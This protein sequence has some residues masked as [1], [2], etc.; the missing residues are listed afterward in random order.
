MSRHLLTRA[1]LGHWTL[2]CTIVLFTEP[3][4]SMSDHSMITDLTGVMRMF[5]PEILGLVF[6]GVMLVVV[7]E[8]K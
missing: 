7:L 2:A 3:E 6:M 4:S 8:A 5:Q 1:L